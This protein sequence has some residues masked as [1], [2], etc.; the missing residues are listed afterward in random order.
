[1]RRGIGS[2]LLALTFLVGLA[3]SAHATDGHFLHG[4]G[5]VNS[6]MGGAGVAMKGDIIGSFYLN[7]AGLAGLDASQVSLGFEMFKPG[8]TVTGTFGTFSG[9]TTSKSDFVP[10]PSFGWAMPL[11]DKV[12]VGLGAIGIGGFGVDYPADT[13]NPMLT[14]RPN[15]FG[16]VYSNFGLLKIAPAIGWQA[17]DKL[18]IG[19]SLNV[20][21]ATL[22]VDPM[23]VASPAAGANGA[24]YSSAAA[25]DGAFGFGFQAGL[26]YD[27]SEKFAI[28]ASYTS[29]QSFQ[30]FEYNSVHAN[31]ALSNF[32]TPRTITFAMDV[33]SMISGGVAIRP[34]DALGLALD[35]RYITYSSTAGFDQQGFD[36]TGAVLGFGWDDIMV[37]A[38]G[39]EL[40]PVDGFFLRGGYN[41]SQ[42]PVP[43]ALSFFNVP[44]PAIVQHHATMG[45]GFS[46]IAG[47]RLDLGYYHAFENEI[48]GPIWGPQGPAPGS[49]VKSALKEDSF[50]IQFSFTGGNR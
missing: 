19:V 47:F 43:D 40:Q 12:T 13:R 15:G 39:I 22:A 44:A 8:R 35:V 33:P 36:N 28:G 10:V 4:V 3:K 6:S 14:P 45:L 48:D 29:T 42:N 18:S 16:Q 32:G 5:A 24:F 9:A 49:S 23:P 7:P 2:V 26:I 21:Y 17:S 25:Q 34:S 1:M 27:I 50:L 31:P 30:D 41:Y 20:D 37:Y 46:P 38:G 11:N